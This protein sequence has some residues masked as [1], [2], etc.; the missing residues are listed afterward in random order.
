MNVNRPIMLKSTASIS[1]IRRRYHPN[2]D[3]QWYQTPLDFLSRQEWFISRFWRYYTQML[4]HLHIPLFTR[5]NA[6]LYDRIPSDNYPIIDFWAE[7]ICTPIIIL[8]S[9][10]L[11]FAWNYYF[12]SAAEKTLW[13]ISSIYM[14]VYGVGG[15]LF[16]GYCHRFIFKD[17][18]ERE[19]LLPLFKEGPRTGRVG[20]RIVRRIEDLASKLRNID[21]GRDPDLE[22][23]VRILIPITI[24]C[25][26]YAICRG[27]VLAEDLVGLRD[28]PPTA[29][30]TVSWSQYV[31]HL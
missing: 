1:D 25:M 13:R 16:S 11:C 9:C 27:F 24:L 21:P 5:P 30:Q 17:R 29:F 7:I 4:H 20:R 23:P 14:L 8:F 26:L 12:P 6:R 10:M 18:L 3:T 22:I 15:G 2:P 28:L 31:P 19:K